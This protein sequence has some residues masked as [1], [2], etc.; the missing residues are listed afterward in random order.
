VDNALPILDL[1]GLKSS[2]CYP[3]RITRYHDPRRS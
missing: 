3:V 2:H 1:H